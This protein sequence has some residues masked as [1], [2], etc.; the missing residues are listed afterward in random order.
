VER[1]AL[2]ADPLLHLFLLV[3]AT[4]FV[5]WEFGAFPAALVSAGLVVVFPFGGGFLPGAPDGRGLALACAFWSVLLLLPGIHA[6]TVSSTAGEIAAIESKRA[7]RRSCG[8]FLAAGMA[9]GFGLWVSVADQAP[10]IVGILVG[11]VAAAFVRRGGANTDPTARIVALPWRAWVA[12]GAATTL[13]AYLIEYFPGHLGVWELRAVHPLYG[14]AWLGGGELLAQATA[15]IERRKSEK[16][17]RNIIF[18][19]M[20]LVAIASVPL[21]MWKASGPGFLTV[22]LSSL[23]LTKLPNGIVASN[24]LAWLLRDGFTEKAWATLLPASLIML[25]AWLLVV[26]Q[27]GPR[28]RAL[29]AFALGPCLVALGLACW[30]LSWWNGFDAVLMVLLVA[31]TVA[32]DGAESSRV[33][34]WAWG[35]FVFTILAL[36][37]IQLVLSS[38]DPTARPLTQL[39][40]EGLIERDFAHWLAK[41]ASERGAVVLSPPDQTTALY[42]Y[43]GLRGLGTVER[44][45]R[46]GFGAAVRIASATTMEEAQ[47]LIRQREVAYI[48]IPSWNFSLD[49][50]ARIGLGQVEGS[51]IH[52]LHHWAL[53]PWLRPVPYQLPNMAGLEGQ[54][55]TI[56]EVVDPQDDSVAFSRI[57]DYFIE[58]GQLDLA[59]SVGQG[60]RRFPA[61]LGALVAR[62]DV[63]VAVGD[64]AG[65]S[66]TFESL[67]TGLSKKADRFLPW[68]RRVSLAVMLARGKRVDLAREQMRRCLAEIDETKLRSLTTGSLYRL[69]VLTKA[70][71]LEIADRRLRE[72]A[73]DLLPPSLRSRL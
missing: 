11:A 24:I 42:Y 36:G 40:V 30:Q 9:G 35:G 47:E 1:A 65:Y 3:A 58:M 50:Y 67:M 32:V 39:E 55:V 63:E 57:A 10:I 45:N 48:V 7:S 28:Y 43:G 69:Q 54:S 16:K 49:E 70:F 51:F 19:V 53:P 64:T 27:T 4:I 22:E 61:D 20:A 2:F 68:D 56:F 18:G 29:L 23:R 60:L 14:F 33:M 8:W 25:A 73:L 66:Q 38:V 17:F 13:A 59:A 71:G 31:G 72:L 21:T 46:D 12:G 62:L 6:S 15:W 37:M 44:G 52:L 26:R 5:A 41:H 34:R